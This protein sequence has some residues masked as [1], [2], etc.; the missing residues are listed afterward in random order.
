[1]LLLGPGGFG[2][3]VNMSYAM[4]AMVH[5]TGWVTAHFHLIFGGAVVIVYF[6]MSVVGGFILLLSVILF[7]IVLLRST[8]AQPAEE[9][10]AVRYALAVNPPHAVAP[11]LN[12]LGFWNA[13][14]F[15][16]LLISCGYPLGQFYFMRNASSPGYS[17]TRE[18]NK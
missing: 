6:I 17:L 4:N 14:L 9:M 1:L 12:G 7:F 3:I 8:L 18:L 13:I 16:L 2:G 11:L 15:A 10:P 5:N